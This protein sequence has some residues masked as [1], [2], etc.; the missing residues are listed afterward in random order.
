MSKLL[1]HPYSWY[2]TQEN[3]DCI[4]YTSNGQSISVRIPYKIKSTTAPPDFGF[5]QEFFKDT[6]LQPYEWIE[7]LKFQPMMSRQCTTLSIIA[8]KENL[9]NAESAIGA[10]GLYRTLFYE[11]TYDSTNMT[12]RSLT[13]VI[14]EP[15]AIQ[16]IQKFHIVLAPKPFTYQDYSFNT[17]EHFENF[18]NDTIVLEVGGERGLLEVFSI[19]VSIN[20]PD[21]IVYYHD[22]SWETL[23]DRMRIHGIAVPEL[24]KFSAASSN[25]SH[26]TSQF[27]PQFN[28]HSTSQFNSQFNPQS[29]SQSTSR[30]T[31]RSTSESTSESTSTDIT[32]PGVEFIDLFR[33]YELFYPHVRYHNV[34]ELYAILTNN[35]EEDPAYITWNE[36]LSSSNDLSKLIILWELLE[37]EYI[38][39]TT[40]NVLHCTFSTLLSKDIA[41]LA[42][43]VLYTLDYNTVLAIDSPKY[44]LVD[45]KLKQ[46]YVPSGTVVE[47]VT[48]YNYTALYL[49][50]IEKTYAGLGEILEQAP[51]ALILYIYSLCA[52]ESE[53]S[54]Q[55][56]VI[57]DRLLRTSN[58]ILVSSGS[59]PE[60]MRS[61]LFP[62]D[63]STNYVVQ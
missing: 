51:L 55:L 41:T 15:T 2:A 45:I 24:C 42:N 19:L 39:E 49:R 35:R 63:Y 52:P 14:T 25:M 1:I 54:V 47:N 27:N 8:T 30:S 6:M 43:T 9:Y 23:L 12:L 13:L 16:K 18:S 31:S 62:E 59:L 61:S 21:R 5:L 60:N 46:L 56:D 29:T 10:P 48:E 38:L 26:S 50:I 3:V 11:G 4:G 37:E 44:P 34:D 7:V 32:I 22:P 33:Y 28:P 53:V 17:G 36:I 40:C 20:P 57:P 58:T